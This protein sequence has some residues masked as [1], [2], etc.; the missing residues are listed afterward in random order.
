MKIATLR[1]NG[2]RVRFSSRW[3]GAAV[4]TALWLAAASLFAAPT[5]SWLSG[6]PLAPGSS[7]NGSGNSDGDI[8]A[9]AT[10]NTPCGLAV[11]LTGNYVYV[12]DRNNNEVRVLE[13]DENTVYHIIAIDGSGNVISNMFSSPV[14]VA[15]DS[16][17]NL[18]VLNYGNG[19]NGYVLEFP[20]YS[21]GFITNLTRL[22]NAGG[23][24]LD[25]S[26]NIYVTASN[27]VFKVTPGGVSNI[28]TTIAAPGAS[29]QGIVV[30]RSGP[31]AG[32]LAVC[33]SGRNGI[34]LINPN[35]GA[36]ATNA[37]FHG[38]GDFVSANNSAASN[39]AK[40]FQPT[41]VDETGD[42]TLVVT[43]YG[44]HRVKAVLANGSVTNIYGVTSNTTSIP[45]S[46]WLT[47]DYPAYGLYVG[48]VDGTVVVPDQYGG[49]AA[50]QPCG[51]VFG[52]GSDGT[53]PTIYVTEDYY[54]IIRQV[55][56]AGLQP[57]LPWPPATP[58]ELA[59]T[60]G[61]GQ[62]TLTWNSSAGATNYNVKRSTSSGGEVTIASTSGT[63]YTYTDTGLLDGTN[64]YYVVSALNTGGESPIS[65]EVSA[66]PLFS[67]APT[68]LIVT[69][70]G[71]G[72]INLA[73]SPSAGASSY[74]VKRSPTANG[75]FTIIA[76]TTGITNSDT[77][78]SNGTTYYY[79]VTAINAGGENPT[80]SPMV[81]ARP[82][83]PPVPDPQIGWVDFPETSTPVHYTS[84]FHDVSP[85]YQAYND[86]YIVIEGTPGTSTFYNYGVTNSYTTNVSFVADPPAGSPVSV[87]SDYADGF[88]YTTDLSP[89]LVQQVAPYLIIKAIGTGSA[90][91]SN[92]SVVTAMFEFITGNPSINPNGGNAAQFFIS[93]ITANAHLYYT[94][95]GSDPSTTNGF[96]IG[97]VAS[98]TNLWTVSFQ[99][100]TNTLFKVRAFRNNYQPSGIVS[101]LFTTTGYTP[102]KISFGFA[103]GEASSDFVASPG[104]T[105]Y[106]PVTL[107]DL[108]G[109]VMYSLQFNVTANSAGP[110]PGPLLNSPAAPFG[111]QSML[112]Q[113]IGTPPVYVPIPPEMFTGVAFTNLMFV[114]TNVNLLGVG[115]M[116][117]AGATNLYDTTK[118]TLITYS[119]AHDD[120][121]PNSLQPQGV[122]VGGYSFQVPG[123]A[124]NGQT[125]QIQIGRPSA[126]SDGIGAPGSSVYIE[127]TTSG[128][129]TNGAINA[130]KNVTIGSRK[131]LVGNVYPFS[132]FNAGDF[133]NTN[134]Q[135]AD[136]EQVFQSAIYSLDYPPAGS[137]F[138]DAM[139]SCGNIG[140]LNGA[141]GYYTNAAVY[142]YLYAFPLKSYVYTYD[143]NTNLV[144][145][146]TNSFTNTFKIYIDTTSVAANSTKTYI[147]TTSTNP[148]SV[149]ST[150][151]VLVANVHNFPANP[152]Y[153]GLF[154]GNDTNINQIAFGDGILDVCDVYVTY[155]RS[156]DTNGLVWF[157][158]FWTNGVRV[159]SA[160]NAPAIQASVSGSS[161][162]KILPAVGSNDSASVTN[163]P[164]VNFVAGDDLQA[165]AG[166]TI[167]IPV[168]ASVFG[169]YPLRVAMLNISVVPLDGSPA[170]TTPISFSTG[171]L[172]KP[173]S[174][175]TMSSGNGNYAT[176][177]LN[178][179]IAGISNNATI[180]TL[181]ITIPTNATSLSAYAVHFDHAS[182]SPNGIASFPKQAL[183]GLITLSS[184]NTSSYNDGI[185][186]S[187]RLRWF[188]T[189]YNLL[190]VS[191]ACPSG[192]G[193]NNWKKYV[194]GVDPNTPNDFPSLN[195]N[196]PPPSGAAMSIYWPTVSSK[197][198]AILSSASLF[199]GNWSTNAVLTGNGNNM[200]FDD[201]STGAVKFYRVLI[202]Q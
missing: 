178:S 26:D 77:S 9:Y 88:L 186:D 132:W 96:D 114:D 80:N 122:I 112:M 184:R 106:A 126:T 118:Q 42:G 138:F 129:L 79:V 14:G 13:F 201:N 124:T 68:N 142:P 87:Q 139:D 92:S 183:T 51:V 108:P 46:G 196:T 188:G 104:Q 146:V 10:Y 185:P 54:H 166:Q 62:V 111:F 101:N 44:N 82:P 167:Q 103:S 180:G 73:W 71:Y 74:N 25:T 117:R 83:L 145:T 56:G 64:Y 45:L 91:Q 76:N 70:T 93:D 43:D 105:F 157:Q 23:I 85:L 130:V 128:S 169:Q 173:S 47:T 172:G 137:D 5:V 30:K 27:Q 144:S 135:S 160:S 34:Y 8:G 199:P 24:A 189:I 153:P 94:L 182:G 1:R 134:L 49:V 16:S 116:E 52:P 38:V 115:W 197:R 158:R 109:T 200:E 191:N 175:F 90:G 59:A 100:Q 194:A 143:I 69:A 32:K 22:T 156:L 119:I 140:V 150:N 81:S 21:D 78:V 165:A 123:N 164:S 190:S 174:E 28:V 31:T 19:T 141:T 176:T 40:F 113:P 20:N 55:T 136:V 18:F 35:S 121:F 187:W 171:A 170:L 63:T 161:G 97:T 36:V 61:Y 29:L 4:M 95:D 11:D 127:A 75:V 65:V 12:A 159:A 57:K 125:Y 2:A 154:S 86:I 99:I 17:Y 152:Y 192:D 149:Y 50:R 162:G 67:P 177:W 147:Y 102:N 58:V 98:A 84:V 133:G 53:T 72:F 195:P 7:G 120:M 168:T 39:T 179:T 151:V 33:D 15:I 6:G 198:Y 89:Y 148:I 202:L 48:F 110:N 3:F 155:R 163:K 41:G 60:A 37:G 107:S 131:Y 66:M 181:F 193:V